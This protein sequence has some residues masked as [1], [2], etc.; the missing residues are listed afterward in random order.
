IM[1]DDGFNDDPDALA[2]LQYTSGST[3]EPKG[4]MLTHRHL[5][6][7][8]RAIEETYRP[9]RDSVMVSWVPT[10]HD[11]GLVY[12]ISM[13]VWS[14]FHGVSFAAA[15]FARRPDRWLRAIHRYRATHS[16]APDTAYAITAAR[17]DRRALDGVDLSSW[18]MALNG[19][20][21]VR[22]QSEEAF[23]DAFAALGFRREAF[24]HSWGLSEATAKLTG[25]QA[26]RRREY[27]RLDGE[28][29]ARHRVV[30][31]TERTARA[32]EL[33]SC[34]RPAEGTTLRIVDPS[35]R[36]AL[37]PDHIGEVW[38]RSPSVGLGYWDA[39][40]V[41]AETFAAR[42]A[43]GDGPWLRTGDLGFLRDG[44]LFV[45][46]RIKEIL[47]IRGQNHAPQDL[48]ASVTGTHPAIRP[49]G[50][51][52]FSVEGAPGEEVALV[53]EVRNA[54]VGDPEA[55]FG[56][57]WRALAEHGL[58]PGVM[59][60]VPP[61]AVPRTTSGK[62][63]RRETRRLLQDGALPVLAT[64]R[65]D[66]AAP[67]TP[68]PQ[69]PTN[70]ATAREALDLIRELAAGLLLLDRPEEVDVDRPLTELG[71]D[72][73]LLAALAGALEAA[74]GRPVPMTLFF[75][76]PVPR[77]LA[78]TLAGA[79]AVSAETIASDDAQSKA[80]TT[81]PIVIVSMSCRFP[82]AVDSPESLWSLLHDGRDA[83]TDF[84]DDRGWPAIE[85]LF[86]LDPETAGRTYVTR[87]GFLDGIDL[88]D[89]AHFHLSPSEARALDPQQRILLELAW[90][91]FERAGLAPDAP[92]RSDTGVFVGL[93]HADYAERLPRA[94]EAVDALPMLG[95]SFSMASGRIA[96][97]LGL[98]GPAITIDTACSASLVALHQAADAIRQGACTFALAGGATVFTTPDPYVWFSRLRA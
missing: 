71:F 70:G 35:S 28:A 12:G 95:S 80:V 60:L 87:G 42:T 94:S 15:D 14:G 22:R 1:V 57:M 68:A 96:Y 46:G 83:I 18:H 67:A 32:I 9:T 72:S 48:E 69:A 30:E 2:Y 31:A 79:E 20:E 91:V 16:I 8:C 55:V 93:L 89:P 59:A 81:D 62:L 88:F 65:G 90:E 34:G 50:T 45:T 19:A 36:R 82:G 39:P 11:L 58:R 41:T 54:Q 44:R 43:D 76:H 4:V 63:R 73:N 51:V 77:A 3:A 6:A 23:F 86:D 52:A 7:N 29:L 97:C 84:P 33:A 75:D 13:P 49:G 85:A 56:A 24:S 74:L 92:D 40:E 26:G 64:A 53:A 66:S 25:E 98:E 78:R 17:A 37:P 5:A 47:I 38:V 21:P 61:G 27:L 10:F